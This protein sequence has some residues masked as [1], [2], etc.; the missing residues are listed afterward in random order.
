MYARGLFISPPPPPPPYSRA[1]GFNAA[2]IHR[3]DSGVKTNRDSLKTHGG[4]T[5]L[6]L[7]CVCGGGGE[8]GIEKENE[9]RGN[10]QQMTLH[11]CSEA[12][13]DETSQTNTEARLESRASLGFP[14]LPP[15]LLL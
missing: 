8:V 4:Q 15:P 6:S 5:P 14:S 12:S 11:L 13:R 3:M 1:F 10:R 9:S 7:S 2:C